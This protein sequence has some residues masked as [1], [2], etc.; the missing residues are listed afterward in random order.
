M[1]AAG[2][3]SRRAIPRERLHGCEPMRRRVP[4]VRPLIGEEEERAV[5][6][7]LDSGRLAQGPVVR[8][9]EAAF[10]AYCGAAHAVAVSNGTVALHAA[11][12][13]FGISEGDEVI[14]TPFSYSGTRSA[15]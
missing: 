6:E 9:F 15:S 2:T 13:A 10:A 14:T 12:R 8:A 7:V 5:F 4:M 11:L 3:G 1:T